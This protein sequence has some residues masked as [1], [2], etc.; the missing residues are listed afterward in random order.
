MEMSVKEV[1]ELW[2]KVAPRME[3]GQD[4]E[5]RRNDT[6][7]GGMLAVEWGMAERY[8]RMTRRVSDREAGE[9][10]QTLYRDQMAF[11]KRVA[12]LLFLRTGKAP[13]RPNCE[14]VSSDTADWL[15]ECTLWE[16]RQAKAYRT[17]YETGDPALRDLMFEAA[18]RKES[19]ASR[20]QSAL[21]IILVR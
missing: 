1:N 19:N 5:V 13:Q 15:R 3:K 4:M 20:L 12:A 8:A 16:L 2:E 7:L 6:D 10:L 14:R 21:E 11:V 17:L 18:K 9:L